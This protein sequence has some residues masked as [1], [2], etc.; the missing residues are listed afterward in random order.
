MDYLQRRHESRPFLSR[1]S[2]P[3]FIEVNVLGKT[4]Q[5]RIPEPDIE[6]FCEK[7]GVPYAPEYEGKK[8]LVSGAPSGPIDEKKIVALKRLSNYRIE[9]KENVEKDKRRLLDQA[10]IGDSASRFGA[11]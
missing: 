6:R 3:S 7:M 2:V 9:E 5:V 10:G 8:F 4:A 1:R 11:A